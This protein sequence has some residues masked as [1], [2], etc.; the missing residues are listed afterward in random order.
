MMESNARSLKH[1]GRSEAIFYWGNVIMALVQRVI[2]EA[3]VGLAA[4]QS[5]V[6]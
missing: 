4:P 6:A 5:L 2:D 1:H 3:G